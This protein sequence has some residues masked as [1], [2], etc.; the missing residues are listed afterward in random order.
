MELTFV[1]TGA[2]DWK[3]EQ[4]G[5]PDYRRF[6]S[7][8][9]GDDLL[10]DPGPHV[11][12]YTED[13]HCPDLLCS[14]KN[15]LLTHSHDDHFRMDTLARIYAHSNAE[16]W[17]HG[18]AM[19]REQVFAGL[20]IHGLHTFTPTSIGNYIVTAVPANHSTAVPT[21]QALHF[22]IEQEGKRI[23]YGCDGAWLLRDTWYYL[24][25]LLFDLMIF[26]CT[27]GD[28]NGDRR[29]FEHNNLHMVEMLADAMRQ[30]HVLKE[31]G[32]IMISHLS[33]LAHETQDRVEARM[34]GSQIAVARDGLRIQ[35]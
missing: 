24:R 27:L 8:L 25:E 35:V 29:I 19:D 28:C 11:F 34:Q 18:H 7:V 4:R 1:G 21:E 2:A 30:N 12:W 32:R 10:I 13:F 23:F 31:N 16:L 22:I 17:C 26:D 20:Q 15:C 3:A 33:R 6:S 14:V 5:E 9:I